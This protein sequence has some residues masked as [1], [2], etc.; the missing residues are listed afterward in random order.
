M[1]LH[2]YAML[3]P[4]NDQKLWISKKLLW[5]FLPP[6]KFKKLR[7]TYKMKTRNIQATHP[8]TGELIFKTTRAQFILD[9]YKALPSDVAALITALCKHKKQEQRDLHLIRKVYMHSYTLYKKF[10]RDSWIKAKKCS[11][12][13][14]I[15]DMPEQVK[16]SVVRFKDKDYWNYFFYIQIFPSNGSKWEYDPRFELIGLGLLPCLLGDKIGFDT[17]GTHKNGYRSKSY[18]KR[19]SEPLRK[20]WFESK[21][22]FLA[23]DLQK[24]IH[25]FCSDSNIN[26]IET[27]LESMPKLSLY[28]HIIARDLL[29]HNS[30][31]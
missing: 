28:E 21:F 10:P 1:C 13:N 27:F 7:N 23:Q 22:G 4:A 14:P 19:Y 24:D 3:A 30:N 12:R 5:T 18:A 16:G 9:M 11:D 17:I 25:I 29:K 31:R 26:R 6:A 2:T 20:C 15:Y 8:E